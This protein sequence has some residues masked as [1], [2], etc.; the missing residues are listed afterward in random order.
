[1]LTYTPLQADVIKRLVMFGDQGATLSSHKPLHISTSSKQNRTLFLLKQESNPREPQPLDNGGYQTA[2]HSWV[3]MTHFT[4][5]WSQ[6]TRAR[7][8]TY[9]YTHDPK[10]PVL[11]QGC[12]NPPG[13][14]GE[15]R[16]VAGRR[17]KGERLGGRVTALHT[18][19]GA[20]NGR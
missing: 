3:Q 2:Q 4:R 1:M 15:S 10:G 6:H 11:R 20:G 17:G 9:R 5:P 13:D 19:E 16:G 7:A 8:T 12:S 14:R 18:R